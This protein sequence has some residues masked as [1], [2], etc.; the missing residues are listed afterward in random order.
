[1]RHPVDV[2]DH[3][4]W[5]GR[6]QRDRSVDA[7]PSRSG[8]AYRFGYRCGVIPTATSRLRFREMTAGDIDDVADMLGD[9]RVMTYYPAPKTRDQASAWGDWSRRNYAEHG[10]GLWIIG[11]HDGQFVGDCGLTWQTV[12]AYKAR[13]RLPRPRRD[14]GPRLRDG[15]CTRVPQLGS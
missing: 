11:T 6:P 13:G 9:P 3:F 7:L 8:C 2:K 10:Y 1:M 5:S 4:G 15:G 14:A 12:T